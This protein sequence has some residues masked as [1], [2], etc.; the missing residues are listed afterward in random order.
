MKTRIIALYLPQFHQIPENDRF[1]GKGYTDW[2]AVKKAKPLYNGHRQP[3][4]PFNEN[5]YDLSC[6]E[7]VRWQAMLA[8]EYGIDGFG[9]YHYWFNNENN[10][11]TKPAEIIRDED[12]DID[13]FFIWDNSSWK[14]SWSNVPGN[15]WAPTAEHNVPNGGP[16]ILI[17]YVLGGEKDWENHYR[18]VTTHFKTAKYIKID[19]KPVFGIFGYASDLLPMCEFWNKLA[20]EDGFDGVHFV[21][22]NPRTNALPRGIF[23]YNYEPH[24][25]GWQKHL[26]FVGRVCRKLNIFQPQKKALSLY[27]YD[28][29]WRYLLNMARR[30]PEPNL[31]HGAFVA[32]DDSP[33]RGGNGAIIVQGSSPAKFE[34]YF[35]KLYRISS[36]QKKEFIFITAW[37]EW[38]EGAYLEPDSENGYEFLFA[39]KKAITSE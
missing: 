23:R 4:V 19:N 2:V 37:N 36:A 35:R 11:L 22:H 17:P 7:N 16:E 1:W 31:Y 9:V 28:R 15:A 30:H 13:Y 25:S 21:F 24:S 32:Y 8:K 14:R 5:Y 10:L 3:R 33:R 34:R 26:G 12:I 18:Y 39:L 27:N 20:Q 6:S 38:G 29:I